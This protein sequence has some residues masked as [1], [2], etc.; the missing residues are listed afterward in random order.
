[1]EKKKRY[2]PNFPGVPGWIYGGNLNFERVLF[3]LHRITGLALIFYL[4]AHIIVVGFRAYSPEMWEMVMGRI[5]GHSNPVILF[6]EWL[7]VLAVIFH[8][9]N[10][11]RLIFLE[12]GFFVG[13]PS[14]PVYPYRTSIDRQRIF[15]WIMMI[16]ASI[17]VI[18][19]IF[20]FFMGGG[21]H[22]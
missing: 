10:G 18:W 17:F 16:L 3:L 4:F 9:F 8:M 22:A 13:K 6:F 11:M 21:N 1:M 5:S 14:R 2:Y 19:S 7:L 20:A 12:L 15:T